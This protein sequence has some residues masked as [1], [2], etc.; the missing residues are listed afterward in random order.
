MLRLL[1]YLTLSL[2]LAVP[3]AGQ[4]TLSAEDLYV[5]EPV[6][7]TLAAP[8]EALTVTYR[9]NSSIETVETI[10]ARGQQT[11]TWTPVQ[12]GVVALSAGGSGSRNVSV[13]YQRVPAGGI[14]VLLIAGCLLFGGAI[15]AFRKLFQDGPAPAKPSHR[16]DT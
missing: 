1:V 16:P 9:P 10:P 13:R 3:A 12:A 2:L 8:A 7:V 5:S 6:T 11:V 15:F 14:V 4:I